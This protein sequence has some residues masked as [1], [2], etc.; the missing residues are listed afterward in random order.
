MPFAGGN[1]NVWHYRETY[2][3]HVGAGG[4]EVMDHRPPRDRTL[5]RRRQMALPDSRNESII[6]EVAKPH[7]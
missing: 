7:A 6:Y 5:A 2:G 1:R 4:E 3:L